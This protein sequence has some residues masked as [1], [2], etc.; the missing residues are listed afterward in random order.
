MFV[1]NMSLEGHMTV[2][3]PLQPDF[4]PHPYT[5]VKKQNV[6]MQTG[7]QLSIRYKDATECQIFKYLPNRYI[8]LNNKTSK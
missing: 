8:P 1:P 3:V 7:E 4:P 6:A 5:F 2:S